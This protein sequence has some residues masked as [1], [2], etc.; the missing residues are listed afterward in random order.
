MFDNARMLDLIERALDADPY[1]PRLRRPDRRRGRDGR[2]WLVCSPPT[3]RT[4]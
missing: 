3:P 1:L 4:A 2:L